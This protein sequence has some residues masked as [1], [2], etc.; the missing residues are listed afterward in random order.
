MRKI[1]FVGLFFSS[2]LYGQQNIVRSN[3]ASLRD[4]PSVQSS[5]QNNHSNQSMNSQNSNKQNATTIQNL[6]SNVTQNV[7][8]TAENDNLLNANKKISSRIE[9]KK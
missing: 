8:P 5:S 2:Y 9:E 1:L 6:N 3:A 7:F 4:L